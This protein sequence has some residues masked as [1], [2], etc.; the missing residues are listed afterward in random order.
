MTPG[1]VR[2]EEAPSVNLYRCAH[3]HLLIFQQTPYRERLWGKS[4]GE[5]RRANIPSHLDLV[6]CQP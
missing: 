5:R 4:Q 1:N 6:Q 2:S 3:Y